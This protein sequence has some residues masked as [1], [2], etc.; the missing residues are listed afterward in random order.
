MKKML[1]AC[2]LFGMTVSASA[3]WQRI[4]TPNDTLQSIRQQA[5]GSVVFSI[6]A[7]KARTVSIAGDG[8]LI[9]WMGENK[10]VVKEQP[11]GVWTF[12]LKQVNPGAYRYHFVVDGLNVYD[13]KSPL[14]GETSAIANLGGEND[15]FAMKDVPHGA[16]SQRYYYSEPLKT[17]RRMHV[18]T[19]AGYEKGKDKL[20]V[21]YL[22]HGGG[23]TDNAW[24]GVGCA[25]L[26]L[27]N[28]LAEGKIV[29]MIV[30][31]PNGNIPAKE[32]DMSD[33]MQNFTDDMM[34]SV[35][36]FVEKNYRVLTDKD[37][38]AMAG[39]SMGGIQTLEVT[40]ANYDK[41]GYVFVLS[42]GFNP[43][44]DYEL[45]ASRLNLKENA[46]KINKSF[47]IFAHTQGGPTDITY[48]SGQKSNKIFDEYGIK[49]E[50]SEPYQSG[51][52]WTTWRNNLKDLAPRL[53]KK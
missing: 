45:I 18:W 37:H 3:Q 41:F 22:V 32:R 49:Y 50:Y 52:S 42:S 44:I 26:I 43:N 6:Y 39:L 25:G 14:A 35:I 5:D 33:M 34:Q 16:M 12:T 36:P 21:L 20:P 8:D 7:P 24:P 23:D 51:H 40:L 13:P 46:E 48:I 19:P 28:L 17:T 53:F 29:P 2:L 9:P 4:P 15:F 31:M 1:V 30:V 47:R 38:R 27:D 11:N 10:P